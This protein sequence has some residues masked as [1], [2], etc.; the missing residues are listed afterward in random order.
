MTKTRVGSG[1]TLM[2]I[3]HILL[4]WRLLMA[5]FSSFLLIDLDI[6]I[7]TMQHVERIG[8]KTVAEIPHKEVLIK[9]HNV[10]IKEARELERVKQNPMGLF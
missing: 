9:K 5:K 8:I 6:S 10:P 3:L 2:G 1:M 7:R 4:T